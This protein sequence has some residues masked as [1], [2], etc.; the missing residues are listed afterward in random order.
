MFHIIN[1]AARSPQLYWYVLHAKAQCTRYVLYVVTWSPPRCTGR[2]R[3]SFSAGAE[4]LVPNPHTVGDTRPGP[5]SFPK[6][7]DTHVRSKNEINESA[8]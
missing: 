6:G 7:E 3:S 5:H 1:R 2:L 4:R 8:P